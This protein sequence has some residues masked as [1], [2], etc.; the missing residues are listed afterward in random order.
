MN[1]LFQNSNFKK[2]IVFGSTGYVG[3]SIFLG[4]RKSYEVISSS[5]NKNS[6][7]FLSE[8]KCENIPKDIDI[9]I[10]AI[11]STELDSDSFNSSSKAT[12]NTLSLFLDR[13]KKDIPNTP[14]I[15]ISTFQ[16]YGKN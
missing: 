7:H 8:E 2:I 16:V 10:F 3:N 5:R 9:S 12:I 4:L 14:I 11:G 13:H 6:S 15:Y 1:N